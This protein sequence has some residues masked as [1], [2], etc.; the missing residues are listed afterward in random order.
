VTGNC[1]GAP[2]DV[3]DAIGRY[4]YANA[5]EITEL[6]AECKSIPPALQNNRMISV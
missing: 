6:Q 2:K 3:G 1:G 4:T 5:S